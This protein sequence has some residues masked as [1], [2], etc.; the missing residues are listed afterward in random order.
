MP[1]SLEPVNA[2]NRLVPQGQGQGYNSYPTQGAPADN[3]SL[4]DLLRL[5]ERH[6]LLVLSIIGIVTLAVLAQQLLSPNNYRS[7][8]QLQVE[9]IDEVG[10]NQADVDSRNDQ[11]VANTVRLHRSR[12]SAEA[13]VRDLNLTENPA[14]LAELGEVSGDETALMQQATNTL[15]SMVDVTSEPGSD[16][17]SIA[18]TA[19]SPELAPLIANRYPDTVGELRNANSN[20]RREGLLESLLAEQ[21]ER[22]EAARVAFAELSEFRGETQMLVGAGGQEDL[23]QVNRIAAEAA[24]ASAN[25]AGSASRSS[26]ISRAAGINSTA[27]ATSAALQQLERQHSGLVAEEAR[28]GAIYGPNHPEIVR[29]TSE[30]ATVTSAMVNARAQAAA[31]AQSVA[32]AEGAQLREMARSQAAQDAARAGRLQ[33]ALA[34]V[35]SRAFRNNANFVK[36]SELER[37]AQLAET[38]YSSISSRI[39]QI[40]AQMQLEG[41]NTLLVSPAA[42]NYDRISPEPVRMVLI[43][44]VGSAIVAAFI[45]LGVDLIDDRLRTSSQIKRLFGLPTLGM[46]PMFGGGLSTEI[47]KSP[48]ISDPQSMFAEAARSTY[49]ELRSLPRNKLGQTVLVTS[50][51]PG[52]G[53]STV[54]LTMAAAAVAMGD[55]AVLVDLDLRKLGLL[56]KLQH[57]L[58]TPDIVD[59]M[60]GRVELDNVLEDHTNRPLLDGPEEI[61]DL[62]ETNHIVLLSAKRPVSDPAAMLTARR[63]NVLIAELREKFDLVV[64]NAPAA[65]AVRDARAMCE[66]AD[67][68]VVVT[69]WGR[70]TIDQMK[71][72][73]E[74]LGGRAAGVIFDQVDYADHARRQFGDSIQYY[75]ESSGYY[76]DAVPPR[77]TLFGQV[78]RFFTRRPEAA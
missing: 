75:M 61:S 70:T 44:L 15:M 17:V 18:V 30:L 68:T 8:A 22:G 59:V 67:H 78:R 42:A 71:A 5:L 51:L 77:M 16:L 74:T 14:F 36:L 12:S 69:R 24:S 7:V 21:E 25:S 53:K 29:V 9:L 4:R 62:D 37:A 32:A 66:F 72:T 57:E 40:R 50:P 38:A 3:L 13:V 49:S 39:E 56:Q 76:T 48:V 19:K 6:K 31:A 35:T 10:T 33:G 34:A 54:S 11:R 2:D 28:L 27:Q 73:I 52:D 20:K 63:L 55:R 43:A 47:K 58:D 60:S 64:I 1:N 45:A 46:L 41:V 23:A 26:V 65:L